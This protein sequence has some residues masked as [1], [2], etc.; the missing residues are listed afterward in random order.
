MPV[1]LELTYADGTKETRAVK[2]L[3]RFHISIG[4]A[5]VAT[6]KALVAVTVD[7]KRIYPDVDRTNNT[8]SRR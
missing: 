2:R 1:T 7:P 8:W 4:R 5:R 6:P 3:P